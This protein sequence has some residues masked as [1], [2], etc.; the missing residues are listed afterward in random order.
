MTPSSIYFMEISE[1]MQFTPLRSNGTYTEDLTPLCFETVA[2]IPL[3]LRPQMLILNIG[4]VLGVIL[5]PHVSNGSFESG[6]FKLVDWFCEFFFQRHLVSVWPWYLEKLHFTRGF[7]A[8]VSLTLIVVSN[9]S[10]NVSYAS[11]HTRNKSMSVLILSPA[12]FS[13]IRLMALMVQIVCL[14][15]L[16]WTIFV[17]FSWNYIR[18]TYR[19]I[20]RRLWILYFTYRVTYSL[21]ACRSKVE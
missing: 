20:T 13:H 14:S 4:L 1:P 15:V 21:P 16:N 9:Q 10:P 11:R 19:N 8:Y 12:I 3:S 18:L 6:S 5:I 17:W 2:K 7:E